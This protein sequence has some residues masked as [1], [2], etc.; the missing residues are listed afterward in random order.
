MALTVDGGA[1]Q[2]LPAELVGVWQT[3]DNLRTAVQLHDRTGLAGF[4]VVRLAG[5]D[6]RLATSPWQ[7]ALRSGIR[8]PWSQLA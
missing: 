3:E 1:S 4:R 6:R 8:H 2:R 7:A 5:E